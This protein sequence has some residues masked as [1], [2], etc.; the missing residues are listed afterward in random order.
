[1]ENTEYFELVK[2]QLLKLG[3]DNTH[4]NEYTMNVIENANDNNIPIVELLDKGLTLSSITQETIDAINT[5]RSK[6][7]YITIRKFKPETSRFIAR[8]IKNRIGYNNK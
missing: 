6:S 8:N 4:I 5:V 7:N 1:M 2:N 3:F